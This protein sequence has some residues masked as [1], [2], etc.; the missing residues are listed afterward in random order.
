MNRE[1]WP[2]CKTHLYLHLRHSNISSVI[3]YLIHKS[4]WWKSLLCR[5]YEQTHLKI[6][7]PGL[8]F[9]VGLWSTLHKFRII[10]LH[11]WLKILQIMDFVWLHPRHPLFWTNASYF[12]V[13]ESRETEVDLYIW[14]YLDQFTMYS[15]SSSFSLN[16][17]QKPSDM[18]SGC[19]R[20]RV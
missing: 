19:V 7:F 2:W 13:L 4:Q 9:S 8:T 12:P 6:G 18:H 1:A 17:F 16:T 11:S 3:I 5:K 10:F 14:F 20:L 15:Q